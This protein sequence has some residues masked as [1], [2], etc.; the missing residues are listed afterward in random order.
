MVSGREEGDLQFRK[1]LEEKGL[2]SE[3]IETKDGQ[4]VQDGTMETGEKKK[5][6]GDMFLK[7]MCRRWQQRLGSA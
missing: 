6:V 5:K 2:V 3:S 1:K 4:A 7:H